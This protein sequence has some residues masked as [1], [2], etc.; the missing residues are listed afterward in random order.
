MQIRWIILRLLKLACFFSLPKTPFSALHPPPP[1]LKI[2][3]FFVKKRKDSNGEQKGEK[4]KNKIT[5]RCGLVGACFF[6]CVGISSFLA[7][8]NK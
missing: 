1:A 4:R 5:G 6:F 8:F 2:A 3:F 7:V